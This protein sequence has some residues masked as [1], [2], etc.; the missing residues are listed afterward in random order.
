MGFKF[1]Y[2]YIC[3]HHNSIPA[4]D[5]QIKKIKICI[6]RLYK[7]LLLYFLIISCD[8]NTSMMHV[9]ANIFVIRNERSTIYQRLQIPKNAF[10]YFWRMQHCNSST[11]NKRYIYW[12]HIN[13]G[14]IIWWMSRFASWLGSH[15]YFVLRPVGDKRLCSRFLCT[16]FYATFY[17]FL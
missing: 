10:K 13:L 8:M 1:G 12:L 11:F 16:W 14:C 17:H 6:I 5:V 4:K 9:L 3:K 2:S 15:F 7:K